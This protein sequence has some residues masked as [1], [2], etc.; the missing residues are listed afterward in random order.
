MSTQGLIRASLN[1]SERVRLHVRAIS[2]PRHPPHLRRR[3]RCGLACL[4]RLLATAAWPLSP[5]AQGSP[6][7]NHGIWYRRSIL[8]F[9]E[10]LGTR[11]EI[12]RCANTGHFAGGQDGGSRTLGPA[13]LSFGPRKYRA[14]PAITLRGG[15][16]VAPAAWRRGDPH[17]SGSR[18]PA[19][20]GDLEIRPASRVD[21]LPKKGEAMPVTHGSWLVALSIIVA[22][23][24]AYVGLS[25]A[26]QVAAAGGFRRRLLLAG[27]AISLAVAI[28]AM[29][30]VGMSAL[31]ASAHLAHASM[32]VAASVVVAIAA[33]GLALWLAA[34]RGGRPPLL[35]SAIALGMAIAG[36]HYTAMAGLTLVPHPGP[37]SGAP[38]LST[39]LL[40]IVVAFVA[41]LVSG[42]FLLTF[43]PDRL[44]TIR[45]GA[46]PPS[47]RARAPE[48]EPDPT[49]PVGIAGT[50]DTH[51][52]GNGLG[53]GTYAP[54]GGAGGPPRRPARHLPVERDGATQFVAIDDIVAVHANAHYAYVFNGKSKLFCPLAIGQIEARLDA[55][56]FIRVHRS[57]IV[58]IDRVAVLKR[59]GDNG[60][61]ELAGTGRY[62]V[63]VSRSRLRW[64]RSRLDQKTGEDGL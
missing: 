61:I 25:L 18:E 56:R 3:R 39:D 6:V 63:P 20:H 28:W 42:I 29:H 48:V 27:A 15:T 57:H 35:L 24:G 22:I 54:L 41:F 5:L 43:V 62:T 33:S 8:S 53:Q 1:P 12:A 34:G 52:I 44:A 32:F 37:A 46:T 2:Q 26:V 50:I 7:S 64:L 45:T 11:G 30:Y 14:Q 4:E 51:L 19:D 17:Q 36:M 13:V 31:H 21:R 49:A 47:E 60:V 40:A 10:R 55:E 58:N 9:Q 59:A 23:Q 38:S 16:T